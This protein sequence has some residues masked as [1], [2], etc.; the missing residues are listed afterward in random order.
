[1]SEFPEVKLNRRVTREEKKILRA[2]IDWI[3]AG[4]PDQQPFSRALS[5]CAE[6]CTD[7]LFLKPYPFNTSVS[8]THESLKRTKHLNPARIAWARAN[9]APKEKTNA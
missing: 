4:A 3:D 7:D 1:M 6:L 9:A 8:F 5:L 2:Y